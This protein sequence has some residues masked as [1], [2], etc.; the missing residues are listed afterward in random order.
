MQTGSCRV[1]GIVIGHKLL[2]ILMEDDL[3]I[4]QG[5]VN[6]LMY[7]MQE[8]ISEGIQPSLGVRGQCGTRQC[9]MASFRHVLMREVHSARDQLSRRYIM[10]ALVLI[11][12][13][14]PS[15]HTKR[16]FRNPIVV[17]RFPNASSCQQGESQSPGR[18]FIP[19]QLYLQD[20][21]PTSCPLI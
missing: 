9:R 3:V 19:R 17:K 8:T 16:P 5:M 12:V 2:N 1:D 7:E 10:T 18:W 13:Q 11:L 20:W 14:A 4:C 21:S 15:A 6:V